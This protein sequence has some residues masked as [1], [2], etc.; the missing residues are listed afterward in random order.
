[1]AE[2]VR[3]SRSKY[4]LPLCVFFFFLPATRVCS[5]WKEAEPHEKFPEFRIHVFLHKQVQLVHVLRGCS[6]L[7]FVLH[8][9]LQPV[10]ESS[11][12]FCPCVTVT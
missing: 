11:T 9:Q 8:H 1:M 12:C 4:P 10:T 3:V 7:W 5:G 6:R 2:L